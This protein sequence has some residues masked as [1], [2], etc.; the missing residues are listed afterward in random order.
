MKHAKYCLYQRKIGHL[1]EQCCSSGKIV[2]DKHRDG[3]IFIQDD[4]ANV[5]SLPF[6]VMMASHYEASVFDFSGKR[7]TCGFQH[8]FSFVL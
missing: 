2:M 7:G 8:A 1:L 4:N 5:D 3:G 6:Q